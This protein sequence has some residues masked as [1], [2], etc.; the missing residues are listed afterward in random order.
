MEKA[1]VLKKIQDSRTKVQGKKDKG[2]ERMRDY[3]GN[4]G[5]N[6]GGFAFM[7][8]DKTRVK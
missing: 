5:V 8:N 6:T 4:I 2:T 3:R 7:L 1:E